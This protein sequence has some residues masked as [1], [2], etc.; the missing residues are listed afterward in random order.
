[1]KV[2]SAEK[3]E[4]ENKTS[5]EH[6]PTDAEANNTTQ[7][8][9]SDEEMLDTTATNEKAKDQKLE[10]HGLVPRSADNPTRL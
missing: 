7:V 1:M 5:D 4:K 2:E 9:E 8:Q 3:E 6:T 10:N